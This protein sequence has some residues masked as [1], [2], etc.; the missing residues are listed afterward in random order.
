MAVA[1][2]RAV[3]TGVLKVSMAA[4]PVKVCKGTESPDK[5][6]A[7][8]QIHRG[9]CNGAVG[10]QNVCKACGEVVSNGDIGRAVNGVPVDDALLDSFKVATDK[11]IEVTEFVPLDSIDRR[12]FDE[13]RYVYP[14]KGG[15]DALRAFAD[16]MLERG[17]KGEAVAA[18]GKVAEREH[19]KVVALYA[20]PIGEERAEKAALVL[21]VLRWPE[22]VRDASPV[23][24]LVGEGK[25]PTEQLKGGVNAL[26]DNMLNETFDPSAHVDEKGRAREEALREIARG[27]TPVATAVPDA[28]LA[29]AD[30]MAALQA[31]INAMAPKAKPSKPAKKTKKGV[32]A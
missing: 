8:H 22:E 1:A 18:I 21:H 17:I 11:A 6:T 15:A 2:P 16:T 13:P 27:G 31:S 19:E 24:E 26:I 12:L 4:V 3:F 28:P 5:E 25:A 23:A 10:R 20:I 30:L 7:L 14:D 9:A 32:A 29:S